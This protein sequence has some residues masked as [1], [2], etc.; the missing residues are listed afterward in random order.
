MPA[1]LTDKTTDDLSS[2]LEW[3]FHGSYTVCLGGP[4][5]MVHFVMD[6]TLWL[7]SPTSLTHYTR[8]CL[9]KISIII[10]IVQYLFGSLRFSYCVLCM[11]THTQHTTHGQIGLKTIAYR[12]L[13]LCSCAG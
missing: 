12:A 5:I 8:V 9:G 6:L 2:D 4:C 10:R 1:T 3:P 11:H 7:D 13:P